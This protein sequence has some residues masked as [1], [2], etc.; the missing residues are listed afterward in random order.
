[1]TESTEQINMRLVKL[2]IKYHK[3]DTELRMIKHEIDQLETELNQ[4][5]ND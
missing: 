5:S 1:M 2:W 3:V 4:R